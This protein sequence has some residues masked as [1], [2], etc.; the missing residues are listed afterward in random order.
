MK[1]NNRLHTSSIKNMVYNKPC[2][3]TGL[4]YKRPRDTPEVARAGS[5][6]KVSGSK[7]GR[8]RVRLGL[9]VRLLG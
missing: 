9:G 8:V 1:E 7:V 4:D 5:L 2:S 3:C 6:C